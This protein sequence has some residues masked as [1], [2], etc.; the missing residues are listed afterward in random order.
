MHGQCK[1][2]ALGA[3]TLFSLFCFAFLAV[4]FQQSFVTVSLGLCRYLQSGWLVNHTD[5][6]L[7]SQILGT[8]H[9]QHKNAYFLCLALARN[10]L[11]TQS[12]KAWF[13]QTTLDCAI[14]LFLSQTERALCWCFKQQATWWPR[15]RAQSR[16]CE[17][18]YRWQRICV[19]A[20]LGFI[21]IETPP[22]CV[23]ELQIRI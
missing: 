1:Q 16:S 19:C 22:R 12:S 14:S 3:R 6:L 18:I 13:P 8:L 7:F 5:R 23:S 4:S 17:H 9:H 11:D 10:F 15:L 20:E 2:F 21:G